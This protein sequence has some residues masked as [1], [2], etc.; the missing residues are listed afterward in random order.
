MGMT[1][2]DPNWTWENGPHAIGRGD[3]NGQRVFKNKLSWYQ[4]WGRCHWISFF[5]C[6]IGVLN[7]P[8]LDWQFVS[9]HCHTV[10]V[11]CRG[12]EPLVV[13]DILQFKT[14][15]AQESLVWA[16]YYP[17][18][19][20]ASNEDGW[21]EVFDQYVAEFV[22]DLR[23]MANG[24]PG[25]PQAIRRSDPPPA[26][27]VRNAPRRSSVRAASNVSRAQPLATLA[28]AIPDRGVGL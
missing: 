21:A 7:Y 18:H 12:G 10:P 6:A 19:A 14:K 25:E 1:M 5:A 16:R 3:L 17:P 26:V 9:G 8:D 11:G 15:T 2:Y 28:V 23:E 20:S 22:P 27:F 24:H 4:P 13:M